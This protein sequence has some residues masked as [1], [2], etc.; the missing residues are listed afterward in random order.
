VE[1]VETLEVE[2]NFVALLLT[3]A[4]VAKFRFWVEM[5]LPMEAT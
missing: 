3:V 4:R 5:A 1:A 2:F